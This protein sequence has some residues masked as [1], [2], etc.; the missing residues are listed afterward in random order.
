MIRQLITHIFCLFTL[1]ISMVSADAPHAPRYRVTDLGISGK[2]SQAE[3]LNNKGQVVGWQAKGSFLWENGKQ[4]II[5]TEI[6]QGAHG[7]NEKG[8]VVG[9][10][11]EIHVF[12]SGFFDILSG[13]AAFVWDRGYLGFLPGFSNAY[14]I[15]D[16]GQ[17][18]G[19]SQDQA[20]L[21]ERR[22]VTGALNDAPDFIWQ[23]LSARKVRPLPGYPYSIFYGLNDGGEAVGVL[24]RDLNNIPEHG[25]AF[26]YQND[27]AVLLPIP[28]SGNSAAFAVNASGTVAGAFRR[29]GGWWQATLWQSDDVQ[30]ELSSPPGDTSAVAHSVNAEGAA[31]GWA[32]PGPARGTS[33]GLLGGGPDTR[34]CLWQNNTA[35]DLNTVIDTSSGWVLQEARA[36]NDKGWIV[37]SGT[38]HGEYHAFLLIPAA[39]S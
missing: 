12:P 39:T 36:I 7:I 31:V 10:P 20:A 18:A 8:Q 37:G 26:R 16:R 24:L 11:G 34:A 27:K 5:S 6:Y 28:A 22:H 33:L 1:T 4:K 29:S 30:R 23:S 2:I 25:R 3:A 19:Q 38:I 9:I 14:S 32:S 35:L 21:W 17:I 15:N 13:S